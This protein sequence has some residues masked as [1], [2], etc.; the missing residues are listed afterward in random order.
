MRLIV[1]SK[2][3][4][5]I[6]QE[7]LAV[8]AQM[9][10][11]VR[12][13]DMFTHHTYVDAPSVTPRRLGKL[14]E[15]LRRIPGVTEVSEA[16]VLP[17][18]ERREQ[19]ASILST[20]Q[21]PLLAIDRFGAVLLANNAA[22]TT[23]GAGSGEHLKARLLTD[24]L[25]PEAATAIIDSGFVASEREIAVGARRYLLRSS[26][27]ALDEPGARQVLG[28]VIILNPIEQ[29]ARMITTVNDRG[30]TGFGDIIG[31]S[32]V[33]Q[34]LKQ[35]AARLAEIDAPLLIV[36]GT[37]VGKDMLARACH[38]ASARRDLPFLAFDCNAQTDLEAETELFGRA[39][40]AYGG[41]ALRGKPGLFELADGGAVLLD[42]VS[43]LS[44]Y[45]Q[46][47]LL[48]FLES[49]E[50][51]RVGA[52]AGRKVDV[53]L[54][55]S[56]QTDLASL[57]AEGRFRE[58]LLYRVNVLS[59]QIPPLAQRTGDIPKLAEFFVRKSAARLGR[60]P[61]TVTQEALWKL[62]HRQW[63]GNLRQLENVVFQTMIELME[64]EPVRRFLETEQSQAMAL[65]DASLDQY[66][67]LEAA[68]EAFEKRI[69][70]A[71][72]RRHKSSRKLADR[73]RTSHSTI[74]RKLRK[75]AVT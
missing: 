75:Y 27:F 60:K 47:R 65:D 2:N 8:F 45:L 67:D 9:N 33:M 48:Q 52:E 54:I 15:A 57:A 21:E 14:S 10:I 23:F 20:L 16:A 28:G 35:R 42:N 73:L 11:D 22:A 12:A 7:M 37:G 56:S 51:R 39:E 69:L 72:Y 5:G 71:L 63:P 4:L 62:R 59:L 50:T 25:S 38:L 29:I 13:V 24:L 3:R 17:S 19:L 34:R 43:N 40:G 41:A 61:P 30:V 6:T 32:V 66:A 49:G 68:V 53:R 1:R 44:A 74:A 18:E 36:G 46:I 58:D 55:A 70:T 26:P 31:D 64:D